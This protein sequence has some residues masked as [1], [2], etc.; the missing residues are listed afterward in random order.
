MKNK[1]WQKWT[2]KEIELLRH[3]WALSD[4]ETLLLAFPNRD[5]NSLMLKAQL[6]GIKSLVNRKRK[7]GSL[8]ML[9]D[10]NKNSFYVWGFLLA[11][12]SFTKKNDITVSQ[13]EKEAI[14]F[15]KFIELMGGKKEK[16][17]KRTTISSY[18]QKPLYMLSYRSGNKSLLDEM[19][20]KIGLRH[21]K[22]Y[23][24]PLNIEYFFV[25]EFFINFMIGLIDGDGCIWV[26]GKNKDCWPNIRIEM[27]Y[28]WLPL[29]ESFKEKLYEFYGIESRTR[30][31]NRGYAQLIFAKKQTIEM[32]WKASKETLRMDRKWERLN[33]FFESDNSAVDSTTNILK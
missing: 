6:I 24:P 18:T 22:T 29:L 30:I 13:Q 17:K 14:F 3:H 25:K 9:K 32:L 5:Y 23:N 1:T 26:S 7:N 33:Q 2:E 27:H 20:L 28:N 4:M 19:S 11:D 10:K 8:N 21:A 15:E 16:I 31:S 12:G